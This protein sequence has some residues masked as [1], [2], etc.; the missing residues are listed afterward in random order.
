LKFRFLIK[1]NRM[2]KIPQNKSSPI[3]FLK[4]DIEF[5]NLPLSI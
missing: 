2:L 4:I 5:V 3:Y 1:F